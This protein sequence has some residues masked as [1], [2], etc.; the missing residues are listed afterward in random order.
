MWGLT[1][2]STHAV[3][4]IPGPPSAPPC[5]WL[6]ISGESFGKLKP[7]PYRDK[8]TDWDVSYP[9]S[10]PTW[11]TFSLPGPWWGILFHRVYRPLNDNLDWLEGLCAWISENRELY[12]PKSCR[13]ASKYAQSFRFLMHGTNVCTWR[14]ESMALS[15]ASVAWSTAPE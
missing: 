4:F 11:L 3:S 6:S 8:G 7:G 13:V 10:L 1:T 12:N 5:L 2:N 9:C 15:K 14:V